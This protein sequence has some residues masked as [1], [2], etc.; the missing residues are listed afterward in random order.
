MK[1][2]GCGIIMAVTTPRE[3]W[4]DPRID[5]LSKKVDAGFAAADKKM[6]ADF[7]KADENMKAGLARVD[8]DIRE[9][10]GEM[11]S[12]FDKFDKKFDRLLWGL[13]AIGV[14]SSATLIHA[15]ASH[16]G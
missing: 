15:I 10:R 5:D 12:G 13:L 1:T 8:A 4:T 7:E 16:G 11:R 3:T 9:L 6:D 2:K 14:S